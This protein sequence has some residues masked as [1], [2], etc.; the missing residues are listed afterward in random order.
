MGG[1][2]EKT[3]NWTMGKGFMTNDE[4]REQKKAE[5]Q[6]KL[7]KVYAG[8]QMPDDELIRR[9]SRRK[10]AMRRG[11]RQKNVLTTDDGDALG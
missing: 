4:R 8:A 3:T 1:L 5:A 9:N 6:A 7:D 2:V 10:A 11:S